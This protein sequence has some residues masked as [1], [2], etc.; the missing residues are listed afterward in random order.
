MDKVIFSWVKFSYFFN[1]LISIMPF[2]VPRVKKLFVFNW[3]NLPFKW[4]RS[5]KIEK[6]KSWFLGI[7]IVRLLFDV[8]IFES[9]RI[10]LNSAKTISTSAG[11]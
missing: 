1:S 6:L 10:F 2:E 7:F 8:T 5:P 11:D 3:V 4:I 9:G